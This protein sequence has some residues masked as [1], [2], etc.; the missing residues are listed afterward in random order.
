MKETPPAWD[1]TL[2]SRFRGNDGVVG[3]GMTAAGVCRAHRL[4]QRIPRALTGDMAA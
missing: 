1:P 2:D 4:I 3:A